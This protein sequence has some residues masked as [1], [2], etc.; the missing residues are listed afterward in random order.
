MYPHLIQRVYAA[1]TSRQV[2]ATTAIMGFMPLYVSFSSLMLGLIAVSRY[3]DSS[4]LVA[5][6]AAADGTF[7]LIAG[8]IMRTG[9]F[10]YWVVVML[11]CGALA[12]LMSTTDSLLMSMS[13]SFVN[14]IIKPYWYPEKSVGCCASALCCAKE[15]GKAGCACCNDAATTPRSADFYVKSG[16]IV[17]VIVCAI[18]VGLVALDVDLSTL[19]DFQTNILLNAVPVFVLGIMYKDAHPVACLIALVF[20]L[21]LTTVLILVDIGRVG[22]WHCG[23]VA[24]WCN[25]VIT[26]VL[27]HMW[28]DSLQAAEAPEDIRGSSQKDQGAAGSGKD[29]IVGIAGA[30]KDAATKHTDR[31]GG[32]VPDGV[33]LTEEEVDDIRRKETTFRR[34]WGQVLYQRFQEPYDAVEGGIFP[35]NRWYVWFGLILNVVLCVPFWAEPGSQDVYIGGLTRWAFIAMVFSCILSCNMAF[36]ALYLWPNVKQEVIVAAAAAA[37]RIAAAE[38][39]ASGIELVAV[40]SDAGAAASGDAKAMES[41]SAR[42]AVPGPQSAARA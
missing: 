31:P 42:A 6:K 37:A 21:I 22:G 16:N 40:D 18:N 27:S 19:F 33:D 29:G 41:K 2:A 28:S 14:D 38:A 12:A 39:K 15:E 13:S 10:G 24:A 8:D 9:T 25:V 20:G 30:V 36:V 34:T 5:Q 11:L 23:M 3:Y 1:K 17:T 7:A 35:I 26:L 32:A 4:D